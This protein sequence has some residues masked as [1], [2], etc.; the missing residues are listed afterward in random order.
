MAAQE[1]TKQKYDE[2]VAKRTE[3]EAVHWSGFGIR[4][5]GLQ[6]VL[7]FRGLGCRVWSVGCGFGVQGVLQRFGFPVFGVGDFSPCADP[8]KESPA[9]PNC[10]PS[11]YTGRDVKNH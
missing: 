7:G 1:S 11:Q 5:W 2:E 3:V 10:G 4:V 9:S 6:Y 8:Y